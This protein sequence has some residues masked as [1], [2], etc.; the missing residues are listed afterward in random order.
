[1]NIQ[2]N[3]PT[4]KNNNGNRVGRALR[5]AA[6]CLMLF[7]FAGN[8]MAQNDPLYVIKKDGHYL[9]HVYNESTHE[10][11]LQN[12]DVF[13]PNC[14]WYSGNFVDVTGNNHNY[15]FYDGNNFRFLS[16]PLQSGG[17]LSLSPNLPSPQLLRNPGQI[18]Y[19]YDW[20][21]D[22]YGRGVAR[23]YQ[24]TGYT[25][26]TCQYSWGDNQCWEVYW[27]EYASGTW[28]LSEGSSYHIT[29]NGGRFRGVTVTE[30]PM[31][32]SH[33]QNGL[34]DLTLEEY[35]ME[36]GENG[37]DQNLSATVVASTANPFS[38]DYIPAYIQYSFEGT[39]HYYYDDLDHT[40]TPV[41]SHKTATSVASYEW[42]ISGEGG[43]YLS[44]DETEDYTSS[45]DPTPTLYYYRP[46]NQGDQLATITVTVTYNT[47][48]TQTSSA[49]VNVKAICQSPGEYSYPVVT[50]EGVT[51]SW[52]P[53]ADRYKIYLTKTLP[54]D[55]SEP[56]VWN[57]TIEVGDVTS[58][59]LTGL[60]HNTKYYYK[61][62]AYC[63]NVEMPAEILYNFVTK[64][65]P[66]LLVYGAI[67][68]GG[69]MADVGKDTEVVIINC[70]SISAVYGGNDIA[71]S[72]LG[73]NGVD[74][75]KITLGVNEGDPDASYGTTNAKIRIG[76]VYGG[77]NGFYAYNGTSFAAATNDTDTI[78]VV[79]GDSV[80]Y[81][82]PLHH[83]GTS[84][85]TNKGTANDTLVVPRIVK[86]AVTVTND[87][88]KIDSLFG[89]AKNAFLTARS[90]N[91]SDITINGGTI[92]AVFGGNN[93]GGSQDHG[94]HYI[95]VTKTTIHLDDSIANTPN[96]GYGRD[97]GIRYLF[98]G[99]NKVAGSTTEIHIEGGQC[100]TIFGGGNLAD[101]YKANLT[102]NCAFNTSTDGVTYGKTYSNAVDTYSGGVITP[103][104]T[105]NWNGL[106]G[107]YNVRTLFGGNNK[108][109][110]QRVPVLTLT[111]GSIGTVYGGG[112]MG[113]MLAQDT[114]N[115]SGGA[116]VINGK[117][118]KYGTH[119]VMDSPT[120][121]IDYLYGG[122][123]RSNVDYSAW[124]EIK[125]GHVGI[126]YGGCNIS[127]DV[128]SSQVNVSAQ[129]QTEDYQ[130][131][132]GGTF[133]KA[134]GG[135]VYKNLFGGSNGFYHCNNGISYI[136]GQDYGDREHLYIGLYIPTHNETQVIISSGAEIKGNVYAGGNMS[137]VG[138]TNNTVDNRPF[139]QFVGWSSVLM[140]GGTVQGSVYGGGNMASIYGSNEA[141]ISGG[142]INGAV[143]GGN[144]R[145]GQAGQ[146]SN[147]IL[148]NNYNTA[149][150]SHTP[151]TDI[152]TFVGI[153]GKPKIN[154]VYG[155]GNGDY[156]YDGPNADMQ[157]CLP[158]GSTV[159]KDKP[160]QTNTFVD[161]NIDGFPNAQT[162][163]HINTVYGGGNGVT[164]TD[165]ITVFLNIK[166]NGDNP[167]VAYNHVDT[168]FGGNNKDNVVENENTPLVPDII[169]LH[170]Q[171]G[172]VYGGCN[173]GAMT[174][175]KDFVINGNT[176]RNVGSMVRLRSSY[177]AGG[178]TVVPSAVVSQA[179]YG[180]CRMNDVTH[181]SLVLV[182]GGTHGSAT[183]FGGCDISGAVGD[184]ARVVVTGGTTGTI[185]GGGN[186]YYTYNEGTV[187]SIAATPVVVATG[188]TNNPPTCRVSR[189][190]LLGGQVGADATHTADV[191]G[192]GYGLL[193]NT[194][195][196]VIVNIG[197]ATATSWTGLPVIF[198][199]IY[200]GSA[201]GTV[202]T[203]ASN[204]TK[205]SFMNGT[206]HG[207]LY[208]GG[209]GDS[210]ALGTGHSNVAAKVNGKVFVNISN[211]NQ[212]EAQCF[213]DLRNAT[214]YGCNNVYGSPQDDVM[215]DVWKTAYNFVDYQTGDKYKASFSGDDASYAI[216]Q[217]FGG[218][219]KAN[220]APEDGDAN[221]TKRTKV[222]VHG[223]QN[224]IQRV[225]SG[226]D[227][228]AAI[229]VL[230]TIQGGRMDYVFGGGN[231]E[232]GEAYAANIGAGG[233]N[234]VV[235]GGTI[236]HLFG[237][238]NKFGN[239]A[240]TIYTE[241]NGDNEGCPENITEFFGGGN[242]APLTTES[243][244]YSIINCGTGTIGE[245][246]GGSKLAD[247]KGNVTLDVEGGNIAP[248]FGGSKGV[249]G[250]GG[251]ADIDGSVTLN[252]YGGTIDQAYGGTNNN[253]N[254]TGLIK[255]NVIEAD[256]SCG[257]GINDV[258]G[259]GRRAAYTPTF[260]YSGTERIAPEV[261]IIHG[262]VNNVV[263]GGGWAAPVASASPKV[264]IGDDDTDHKAI[265]GAMLND[266]S[267]QGYGIVFGGGDVAHVGG[268]TL[269]VYDDN[270]PD[271]HV[272]YIFGGGNQAGVGGNI[273]VNMNNGHLIDTIFGGCN[274]SGEVSGTI[275]VTV[276]GG[277][278]GSVVGGGNLAAY[279]A[280]TGNENYP[281]VRVT[282][283]TVTGMVVGGGNR[284]NIT[285]NPR[286]S[287]EGGLIGTTGEGAGVYGG[288]NKSGTV[289][290]NTNVVLTGGTVGTV[291]NEAYTGHIHGGGYGKSTNVTG[292]VLVNFGADDD[293]E[294]LEFPKL[295]GDLY[296][297]SALGNVNTNANNTTRIN[298]RNGTINGAVYGGGLG[299]KVGLG[300]G[301]ENVE[302]KV[303]GVVYINV[304]NATDPDEES[305]YTGQA[306]LSNCDIY[307]CN[308]LNGSPQDNVYLNVYKTAHVDE[309]VAD[310]TGNDASYAIDEVFGG[311]NQA[312][313]TPDGKKTYVHIH[314]CEN[315]IR[316]LFGGGN[317]AY[318]PG[319]DLTIDGGRLHWVFGGGNGELGAA[320][321][322]NI[323]AGGITIHLGGGRID[324]LVNGSN[325]H[326]D[327]LEGGSVTLESFDGCENSVVIDHFMGANQ[328]TIYGNITETIECGTDKRFVNLYCGSNLAQ[329]Y[330]NI[331]LT[332]EGGV[333]ENVFG[334]SKG[335]LNN[336]ANPEGFQTYASSIHD[337]PNTPELEG[338]VNLLIKGGTIGNIFG[339]C[340][341][342]GNV[343]GKI[344]IVVDRDETSACDP[345]FFIGNI[346]GGGNQT[347]YTPLNINNG[348]GSAYS[349]EIII[350][351]GVIGGT[352]PTDSQNHPLLPVLNP[353]YVYPAAQYEGN[354]FGGGNE[355]NV[356]GEYQGAIRT[357]NPKIV[358][359]EKTNTNKVTIEGDVFGGGNKGNVLGSPEVIIVP[360]E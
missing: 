158:A 318:V 38:Y 29:A 304:G 33:E 113:D 320:Y 220:Y 354:V 217:V 185:F 275:T 184:T 223:C 202:N 20:D 16:A 5:F 95:K 127:G 168:I 161:I 291:V 283:G 172:T 117:N 257:L 228:A 12:A 198:G 249:E 167:P 13:S 338:H 259:G 135:I 230:N 6:C 178:T 179:V 109:N 89:G 353:S 234:L 350:L 43:Y 79:P 319:I 31:A 42:T 80:S 74:G 53:T 301:H 302:A 201:L 23:G 24:H 141:K 73:N 143:Y 99:G 356:G 148:P 32:V 339:A 170:G 226:G 123:Q 19:F 329:I 34:E 152:H 258:Y 214:V 140:D 154:T 260:T 197:P 322:A 26:Q 98:G 40:G 200:G 182:E 36:F 342:N 41:V 334:G 328:T 207:S 278:T 281:Y 239:I 75:S 61:I 335:S 240:G 284:A 307:G 171:V 360:A 175:G 130:E 155:G 276:N 256:G 264:T 82:T 69:R 336:T 326:G 349:P 337:N 9:A 213:I 203:D 265:V 1:M 132:Q 160:I 157:Y 97:F 162:G 18:Y 311:G 187:S 305:T 8:T 14:L 104:S 56:I 209:L 188:V 177:T 181:N 84:V 231:G 254:I 341:E 192:G 210:E 165:N 48:V 174:T 90:G 93:I 241:V 169:L 83:V 195:G 66:G 115:G 149:S 91:G 189:V 317:A 250:D 274:V 314:K 266:N 131:V 227:A 290:G 312:E 7:A 76:S 58:Y 347:D 315:T 21:P 237:G 271:S 348:S 107:I 270:H 27:V 261:N 299:D 357:S 145:S 114:D 101:V 118:V 232:L 35:E 316:R 352:S 253:G 255:V 122:C 147:R 180:G 138:F 44:F 186:G 310:Y 60:E 204:T 206:L 22:D 150:D 332:I 11:E 222:Y 173:R 242:E 282:N 208:G 10:W 142:T 221:S 45:D 238:S 277:T 153:T 64:G 190:D 288:C 100:D 267:G 340:D 324:L 272:N 49:T 119:V 102:V 65:E 295:F 191:F 309:N 96:S 2:N 3:H 15:Y 94:K 103:K 163:G 151:L 85:W 54:S 134:T 262:T 273:V 57:T 110:M 137:P 51:L 59:T 125:N 120:V 87:Y 233:T 37:S 286:V 292:N 105:Y 70:D 224:T 86:T 159:F 333:F 193:T 343:D 72:V 251:A 108:A 4:M 235:N 268:N 325:E 92:L 358:I 263:Y 327:V 78:V 194:S 67:F 166:G 68:G 243:G 298:L 287:I 296:G 124:T 351:K 279:T 62:A 331:S 344:T 219:H 216:G 236:T 156:I 164:V 121:L 215:V 183:L 63:N 88:V 39:N 133:V 229:G 116:L 293:T 323:G 212:T 126:V 144:D 128:G 205:V 289:T 346:Y 77:G 55:P 146:I 30:H 245:V 246:Y 297:G 280:P 330:G 313:F 247:I 244:I 81:M 308:N 47:G 294:A 300:T 71:G 269:V 199:D 106:G 196:N 252:L 111:S 136:E 17:E 129:S 52:Y 46:N 211:E 25:E 285:G 248:V 218:G 225:F 303:Y 306:T 28:K 359:G 345:L 139:P 112:N 355:G 176:Y 50:Y 321:A